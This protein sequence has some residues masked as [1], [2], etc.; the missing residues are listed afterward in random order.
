MANE[1]HVTRAGYAVGVWNQWRDEHPEIAPDLSGAVISSGLHRGRKLFGA[2][3]SGTDFRRSNMRE[4]LLQDSDLKSADLS[5]TDLR[6]ANLSNS[7][8]ASAALSKATLIGANLQGANLTGASLDKAQFGEADL[9]GANLENANLLEADF[10]TAAGLTQA[11]VDK[12]KG[13]NTTKLPSGLKRPA[14]WVQSQTA[15]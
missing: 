4:V 3:L 7:D 6:G 13:D 11:Q 1:D 12:G 5:K 9:T 10:E 8:L 2:N 14:H 15:K